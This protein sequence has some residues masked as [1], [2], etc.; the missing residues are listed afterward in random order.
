RLVGCLGGTSAKAL[1][2]A[3]G[4]LGD[5]EIAGELG[6]GGMGTVYRARERRRGIDVALKV[7]HRTDSAAL[8]RFKQEFRAL[9]GIFHPNL[10]TLHQLVFDGRDWFFTM[11]LID[12]VD[13][14][15]H[16]RSPVDRTEAD[17]ESLGAPA[18]F[19]PEIRAGA[20]AEPTSE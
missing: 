18:R 19:C 4:S 17:T 6:R 12:G 10:V 5:F 1:D 3:P 16:V 15:R 20:S 13:F 8:A 14:L 2:T 9:A 11:E 7:V